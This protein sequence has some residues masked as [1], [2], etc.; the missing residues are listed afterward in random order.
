MERF[1]RGVPR[2]EMACFERTVLRAVR[3]YPIYK[4]FWVSTV[5]EEFV[6]YQERA[7]EHD[8]HAVAVYGDGDS[9]DILVHLPREFLRVA[10]LFLEQEGSIKDCGATRG[11]LL[12]RNI[13]C[14]SCL[15]N[16]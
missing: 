3:G 9:N 6:C 2:D 10:F 8:R 5:G 16:Y 13:G 7:N 11:R 1:V 15:V 4:D 14:T 12:W